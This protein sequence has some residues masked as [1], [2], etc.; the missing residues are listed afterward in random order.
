MTKLASAVVLAVLCLTNA[1][2]AKTANPPKTPKAPGKHSEALDV[3][4]NCPLSDQAL[5]SFPH[6][7]SGYSVP[8]ALASHLAFAERVDHGGRAGCAALQTKFF[9]PGK[10]HGGEQFGLVAKVKKPLRLWRA[11]TSKPTACGGARIDGGWW[12]PEDPRARGKAVYRKA[13]AV[14]E[15]WNDF[16]EVVECVAQLG[17]VV[18]IGPTESVDATG[19][20]SCSCAGH[21]AK[22]HYG[23]D[24]SEWQVYVPL[25]AK[26]A[27][28]ASLKPVFDC[29]P[30]V[31][32]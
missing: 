6:L 9:V 14:C 30:A 8:A 18:V 31:H 21:T 29:K 20:S 4:Q 32:W 16:G 22:D 19:P 26:G 10:G 27:K 5:G 3:W 15:S 1:A 13:N 12:T 24:N 25:Y 23:R 17:A 11:F 28:A 2:L 7:P